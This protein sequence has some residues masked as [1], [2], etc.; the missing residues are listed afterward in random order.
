MSTVVFT[1]LGAAPSTPSPS[2]VRLYINSGGTLS[3]VDE[4]GVVT[5][6]GAGVTQESVEDYVG[7]LI[8]AGSSKVTVTYNDAG[9]ALFIDVAQGNIDHNSLLNYVA[10]R[11]IDHT[12]V[13]VTAGDGLSGGGNIASSF[14]LVNADKGST[15]V[16]SHVALADPHPQYLT[17]A[18]GSAAYQ[19]L[20]ADL[21]ALAALAGTGVVVRTASNTFTTRALTAG[22]G[23]SIS[24]GDGISGNPTISSNI[25][26]YTNED[27]Q[28]A[29]A[30]ALTNTG[31]IS[32]A[33]NDVSNTLS[34]SVIESG[35]SLNSLSG[36]L[37]ISKGGTGQTTAA[38][39]FDALA[40]TN[41]NGDLIYRAGGTNTRLASGSNG[42]ILTIQGG[43]P[44][45][46]TPSVGPAIV[47]GQE[48]AY[49][50]DLTT[51][52]TTSTTFTDAASFTTAIVP[53]GTYRIAV[54]YNWSI[55]VTNGDARFR[56]MVDG[57]QQGPEHREE[58][59]ETVA[60]SYWNEGWEHVTFGTSDA[61]T[62]A[63]QFAAEVAGNTVS[64]FQVR[65]EFWRVA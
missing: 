59:S 65:V 10:N 41:A 39:A 14:S 26:Q 22:T 44:T 52:A 23:I 42:Q 35:L 21:T 9:N 17:A 5:T 24:N 12:S 43:M 49:F 7:N 61:H 19:P 11:H 60:Q 57:V 36:T 56:F 25:T 33:Y 15:A 27:A 38:A 55:N 4:A 40:P 29:V 32:W 53:A 45:W 54:F 1:K 8:Q 64:V 48:Y 6:Y 28:D 46:Q 37:N 18:E 51:A 62:I 31:S 50:S 20:D 63:L 30:S 58:V 3:S 47:F 34:A 2:K 13:V 16:A